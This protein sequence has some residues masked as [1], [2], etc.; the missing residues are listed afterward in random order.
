MLAAHNAVR[1]R[2]GVPALVWSDRLDAV[3]VE[4]WAALRRDR[5]HAGHYNLVHDRE[6]TGLRAEKDALENARFF[7]ITRTLRNLRTGVRKRLKEDHD[8]LK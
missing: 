5:D 4:R 3:Y 1:A 6:L 7:G 2:V 8:N